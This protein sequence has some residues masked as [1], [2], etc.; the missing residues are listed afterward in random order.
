MERSISQLL[1]GL[2]DSS[3][4]MEETDVVS[5]MRIKELTDMKIKQSSRKPRRVPRKRIITLALAAALILALGVTAYAVGGRS[6]CVGTHPMPES[7]EFT[8]LSDLPQVEAIVGY[9]VSLPESFP[10]GYRFVRLRVDGEAVYGEDNEVLQEYYIVR[11][12][13]SRPGAPDLSLV[14]SP[15]QE[16]PEDGAAQEPAAPTELRVL[17]GIPVSLSLDHYKV[18][19]EGY[20]KTEA[21]LAAEAEGHYY[22][23]FGSDEIEEQEIAFAHFEL[24]GVEYVF[25]DMAAS[26]GSLDALAQMAE[27]LL[28]VLQR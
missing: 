2:E 26:A 9:P 14:L 19:P 5:A 3:V 23:S 20:E 7:G 15:V 27:E 18:V 4:P 16:R 24:A 8:S 10:N 6:R 25:T 21:D 11:A 17:C 12:S 22:I 28:T 1:D 13:Y